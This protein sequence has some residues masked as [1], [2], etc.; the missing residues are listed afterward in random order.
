MGTFH[1]FRGGSDGEKID[2]ILMTGAWTV[3]SAA[4]LRTSKG[5]RYPS[6]HYPVTAVLRWMEGDGTR[7]GEDTE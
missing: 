5:D 4:I 6:D 7:S 1:G 2:T 3:E